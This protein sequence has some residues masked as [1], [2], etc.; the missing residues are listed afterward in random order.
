MHVSALRANAADVL[1]CSQTCTCR[2]ADLAQVAEVVMI[3][4]RAMNGSESARKRTLLRQKQRMLPLQSQ[5]LASSW[6]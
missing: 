3:G 5:K 4:R 6:R 1:T 2:F